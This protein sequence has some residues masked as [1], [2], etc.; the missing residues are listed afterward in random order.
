LLE[1]SLLFSCVALALEYLSQNVY[2]FVLWTDEK[3]KLS[4]DGKTP[5]R[6][7]ICVGLDRHTP[8]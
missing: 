3:S 7:C 5:I 1:N 8:R 6:A 2:P 4:N